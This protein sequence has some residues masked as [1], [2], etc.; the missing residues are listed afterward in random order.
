MAENGDNPWRMRGFS[1]FNSMV[2]R[3]LP[4]IIEN[5]SFLSGLELP[6]AWTPD[7]RPIVLSLHHD[8]HRD[9]YVSICP[10]NCERLGL[11]GRSLTLPP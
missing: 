3:R 11:A 6:F 1:S 9:S 8:E 2:A 7:G 10:E 5:T 4:G